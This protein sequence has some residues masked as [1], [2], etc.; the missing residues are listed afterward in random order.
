[1]ANY[2]VSD[3]NLSA[4]ANAIRT[5]SGTSAQLSFP[6]GFV[7]AIGAIPAMTLLQTTSLGAVSTSSTTAVDMGKTVSVS[8]INAYDALLVETSVDT[9]VNG[10]HTCTCAWIWLTA[11]TTIS[12]K[13]GATIATAK[14]NMRAS[15]GGATM[16][17]RASTTAYGIYPND[18]TISDGNASLD[19]YMRY[20]S[21]N[22]GTIDNNYTTRVYGLKLADMIGG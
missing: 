22:T 7:S 13:S 18:C 5:K 16:V 17:V 20:H 11:T 8:N 1:M 12:T 2:V 4:V 3:T 6:D 19:M 10:R 21:T 15:S 14:Q 9:V